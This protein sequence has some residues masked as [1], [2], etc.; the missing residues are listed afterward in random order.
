[1]ED[2]SLKLT[3]TDL[4]KICGF[5]GL[6]KSAFAQQLGVT[7]AYLSRVLNGKNK[8]TVNLENKALQLLEDYI[9]AQPK[10]LLVQIVRDT[11]L[12]S[13]STEE[14]YSMSFLRKALAGFSLEELSIL[15]QNLRSY[16]FELK[17]QL[18]KEMSEI[19]ESKN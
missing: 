16:K 11:S 1:M 9:R 3:P 13:L 5:L 19:T 4:Y 18:Q 2:T 10:N 8:L 15:R 17:Y 12:Q 6:D 7:L 14:R